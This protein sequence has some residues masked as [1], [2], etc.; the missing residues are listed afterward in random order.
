MSMLVCRLLFGW[1]LQ[2]TLRG[3]TIYYEAPNDYTN[4]SE[5]TLLDN[6]CVCV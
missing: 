1:V 5:T 2:M 6:R 4:N 3:Q